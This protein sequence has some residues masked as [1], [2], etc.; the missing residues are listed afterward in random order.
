MEVRAFITPEDRLPPAALPGRARL[1]YG[2]LARAVGIR[3][4]GLSPARAGRLARA[5]TRPGGVCPVSADRAALVVP[6]GTVSGPGRVHGGSIEIEAAE[7]M[8]AVPGTA[9]ASIAGLPAD[10][11][12]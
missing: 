2:A 6:D 5:G 10:A 11:S 12:A 1:R 9:T 8:A 3:R 4:G 7:L